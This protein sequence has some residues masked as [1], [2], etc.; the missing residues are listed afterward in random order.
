MAR[1]DALTGLA[2]R[3][4]LREAFERL[5]DESQ[6]QGNSQPGPRRLQGSQ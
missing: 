6:G 2:N 5:L 1:H 4:F 3:Q